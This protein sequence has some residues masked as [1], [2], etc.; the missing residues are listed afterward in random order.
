[1][2][3]YRVRSN[4][5]TVLNELTVERNKQ[6]RE[7]ERIEAELRDYDAAISCL[8]DKQSFSVKAIKS[9]KDEVACDYVIRRALIVGI[10]KVISNIERLDV[11]SVD[12][13][14]LTTILV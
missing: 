11:V 12:Y 3:D 6:C 7:V 8:T 2:A 14:T 5:Q 4:K 9:K 10:D 13:E 1:M